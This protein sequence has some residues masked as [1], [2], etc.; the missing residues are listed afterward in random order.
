MNLNN[1]SLLEVLGIAVT[2]VCAVFVISVVLA[3]PILWLWN[4]TMPELFGLRDISW[5]MAW[6]ISML[7]SFLFKIN[8]GAKKD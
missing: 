1:Y 7:T 3:L 6:K 4:S 2:A 8:I 5:W